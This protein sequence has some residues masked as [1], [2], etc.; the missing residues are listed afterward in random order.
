MLIYLSN[1]THTQYV[2]PKTFVESLISVLNKTI[3]FNTLPIQ[4]AFN[5]SQQPAGR[6]QKGF[7][8]T[9]CH[10]RTRRTSNRTKMCA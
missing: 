2:K 5:F 1:L 3:L 7:A 6:D 10:L 4:H 9:P 8:Q